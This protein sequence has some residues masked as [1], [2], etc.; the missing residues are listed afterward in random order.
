METKCEHEGRPC[1]TK[2]GTP[3]GD[4][5]GCPCDHCYPRTRPIQRITCAVPDV[6]AIEAAGVCF[7]PQVRSSEA[8]EAIFAA[9]PQIT[10]HLP[11]GPYDVR[12]TDGVVEIFSPIRRQPHPHHAERRLGQAW[13]D[14]ARTARAAEVGCAP[15]APQA[16]AQVTAVLPDARWPRLALRGV[17]LERHVYASFVGALVAEERE[18]LLRSVRAMRASRRSETVPRCQACRGAEL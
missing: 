10:F 8:I 13:L 5:G 12:E 16:K 18:H 17:A 6:A 14:R 3:T 2:D 11:E 15:L 4:V 9:Q 7:I 1:P